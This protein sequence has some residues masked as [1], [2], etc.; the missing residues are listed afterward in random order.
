MYIYFCVIVIKPI[1]IGEQERQSM[2]FTITAR[3]KYLNCLQLQLSFPYNRYENMTKL[4]RVTI[5][6]VEK[7]S[8]RFIT[9]NTICN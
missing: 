7:S 6:I 9:M 3:A 4:T 2:M 8:L 5:R 1:N